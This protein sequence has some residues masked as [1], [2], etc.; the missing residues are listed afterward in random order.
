MK[1]L[2]DDLLAGF[3]ERTAAALKPGVKSLEQ[4]AQWYATL[5]DASAADTD[6]LAWQAWHAQSPENQAAWAHIENVSRKFAPLRQHGA[7][8]SAAAVASVKAS[9]SAALGRRQALNAL[10]GVLG[11]GLLSWLGWRHTPLPD[12]VSAWRAD[13]H[14]GT[15]ERR[16][17]VLADGSRVWLNTA[18]ALQVRFDADARQLAL[19]AGEILI[20]TA[21]DGMSRPFYVDTGHGRLQALGTRF[22]V[23]QTDDRTRLDVFDGVVEI[24]SSGGASLRVPAGRAAVFDAGTVSALLDADRAREAWRRGSLPADN[25]SLGEL[26]EEIGRYHRG[27]ISVAAEVADLK[28]MGVYPA[29][30]PD[31]ALAMLEQTLP[32]RVRRSLPWWT[33]V[34]AR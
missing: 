26:L 4:A 11:L 14:T 16:E 3:G 28:V 1:P 9:R 17:L 30:N 19:L 32:I 8:G 22:T 31:Q 13:Y 10:G 34:E 2:A 24:R 12:L 29:D 27:H 33:T 6:R 21:A 20:D 25:L 7:Q 18:T 5:L 15:G 23:R